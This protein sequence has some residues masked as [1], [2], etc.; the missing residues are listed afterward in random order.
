MNSLTAQH[1][2]ANKTGA[3]LFEIDSH[4]EPLVLPNGEVFF[5]NVYGHHLR[6]RDVGEPERQALCWLNEPQELGAL[7]AE[8]ER[9]W[10]AEAAKRVDEFLRRLMEKGVVRLAFSQRYADLPPDI[11][12]RFSTQLRWLDGLSDGMGT[13]AFARLRESKVALVGLGG[14]GSLCA[15]MLAA[16]G[17]G[18]LTLI[19][20]DRVEISNLVRQIFYTVADAENG[21]MKI[22]ALAERLVAFSPHTSV[23]RR[24]LFINSEDE[25]LALLPGHDLV[26]QTADAPRIL[27][28]RMINSV[29][30][31]SGTPCLFSFVGQVGPLF[32]PRKSACFACLEADWRDEFGPEHDFVVEALRTQPTRQHPSVVAAATQIADALFVEALGFLSGAYSPSTLNG[33]IRFNAMHAA[34][35]LSCK[36]KRYCPTCAPHRRRP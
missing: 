16:A 24:P 4:W 12:E 33:L 3:A 35:Q 7:L 31:A 28:H 26:I 30:M 25:G 8:S 10:G 9:R 29:C 19:D 15:V 5:D 36:R 18:E 27:L 17:V 20:G 21:L 23:V 1:L 2:K 6:V 32:V 14:A 11:I 34:T 13:E 22:D